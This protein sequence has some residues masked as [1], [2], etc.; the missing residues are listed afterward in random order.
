[1]NVQARGSSA[2]EFRFPD[3]PSLPEHLVQMRDQVR[4]FVDE[5]VLPNGEDWERAGKIPREIF[6]Q[7]GELGLLGMRY[8]TEYGG[9]DLGPL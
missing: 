1:M 2:V 9:T 4:R 3:P 5:N 8:P 7:M 6:R